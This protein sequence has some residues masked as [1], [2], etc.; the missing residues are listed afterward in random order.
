MHK[1]LEPLIRDVGCEPEEALNLGRDNGNFNMTVL[2][3]RMSSAANGVSKLHGKVSSEMWRHLW[4]EGTEE[5]VSA[6]TNGVHTESWIGPEMRAFYTQHVGA[7][8]RNNLFD[9]E[10]WKR[11]QGVADSALWAAH[12]AQKERLV[13]FAREHVR[14]Q[15][16]RHGLSP[17]ELRAI[18][19]LLDPHA[20]TIGFARRFATYKRATS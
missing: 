9:S 8:W 16:A 7:D 2:A 14:Q 5:P 18:E 20:L 19:G 11:I 13:R 6:I 1:Y 12:R 10:Y 15:S 3:I 4:P 17:D